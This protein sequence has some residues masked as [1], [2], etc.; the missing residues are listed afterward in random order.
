MHSFFQFRWACFACTVFGH[1]QKQSSCCTV[2]RC[3]PVTH[4]VEVRTDCRD[5]GLWWRCC[6]RVWDPPA[7]PR[8][9]PPVGVIAPSGCQPG[10]PQ[11][12]YRQALRHCAVIRLLTCFLFPFRGQAWE[13]VVAPV[14]TAKGPRG[15]WPLRKLLQRSCGASVTFAKCV[16]YPIHL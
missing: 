15:L 12:T 6:P 11:M 16:R 14:S 3:Q 9:W 2:L 13:R 10:C 1:R 8:P 7:G 5:R 4:L